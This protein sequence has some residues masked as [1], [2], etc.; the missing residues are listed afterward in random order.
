MAQDNLELASLI[1][2]EVDAVDPTEPVIDSQPSSSISTS[3]SDDANRT[4][5]NS[6]LSDHASETTTKAPRVETVHTAHL[7]IPS[8]LTSAND[9]QT[10]EVNTGSDRLAH[11]NDRPPGTRP[12]NVTPGGSFFFNAT[13]L[14]FQPD[15]VRGPAL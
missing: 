9:I 5:T 6:Q 14:C 13:P 4:Q 12:L 7:S 2:M 3:N 8:D 10:S 15:T 11:K 1:S